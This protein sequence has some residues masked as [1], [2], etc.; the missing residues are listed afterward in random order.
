[1]FHVFDVWNKASPKATGPMLLKLLQNLY[2]RLEYL[3]SEMLEKIS[4]N[5]LFI[6]VLKKPLAACIWGYTFKFGVRGANNLT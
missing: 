6:L 5:V 1:M 4:K 2:F 3:Y